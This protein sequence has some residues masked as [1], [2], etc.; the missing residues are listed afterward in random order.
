MIRNILSLLIVTLL[1]I[2]CN[3]QQS[4][5][6][7]ELATEEETILGELSQKSSP[8]SI[9]KNM[10]QEVTK[11]K[12][13]KDGRVGM[14][15]SD[16]VNT[17]S[18]I[19]TLINHYGGY[20]ANE[21]LTNSEWEI[22]YHLKIRIPSAH[23][24]RF[25]SD[26]ESGEGEILYK[27]IDARDI[28]DQFIDLET[29]LDNKRNYQK[30][31]N[32]LLIKANSIKEILEIEEKIRALEEEI[33]STTGQLLYLSDLVDYSTLDLTISQQRTFKYNPAKRDK[34]SEKVRQS[35][36][37]GWFGLVDFFLFVINIWP[38]W[39]ILILII[40]AWKKYKMK[41]RRK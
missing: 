11:K 37:K 36:S 28:T 16:L 6:F 2:S 41:V 24:M 33:E 17:K 14:R 26:T 21:K 38:F 4:D 8:P 13:I 1:T 39:I 30:R 29:R 35:F 40:Y 22:A 20:Y 3:Q 23:F 15:V 19:D 34:F 27:E 7:A 10:T 9:D 25:I 31:Y 5:Q 12:I 32:D 18:R